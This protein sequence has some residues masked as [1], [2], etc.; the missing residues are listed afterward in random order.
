MRAEVRAQASKHREG[1]IPTAH[2]NTGRQRE[3]HTD[4][5]HTPRRTQSRGLEI[6]EKMPL[7]T[8]LKAKC[9]VKLWEEE[10][11]ERTEDTAGEVDQIEVNKEEDS[12]LGN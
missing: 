10:E 1:T 8:K 5:R 7:P 2:D 9:K 3:T 12:L 6:V 4:G 11:D